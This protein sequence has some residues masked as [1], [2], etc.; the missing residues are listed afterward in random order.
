MKATSITWGGMDRLKLQVSLN[1]GWI[2]KGESLERLANIIYRDPQLEVYDKYLKNTQYLF[3]PEYKSDISDSQMDTRKNQPKQVIPYPSIAANLISSHIAPEAH[4]LHFSVDDADYQ[5]EIDDFIK[6]YAFWDV[7]KSALPSYFANGSMFIRFVAHKNGPINIEFEN[8]KWVFP[9]FN[10]WQELERVKIRRI[11]PTNEFEKGKRIWR[12]FQYSMGKNVDIMY[13]NPVFDENMSK[14]PDFKVVDSYKHGLG[15]VQGQWFKTSF[16]SH[17]GAD[18]NSFLE[19]SLDILD[20]YNYMTSKEGSSIY[21]HLFPLLVAYGVGSDKI[22]NLLKDLTYLDAHKIQGMNMMAIPNP[23]SESDLRFLEP[24][25]AGFAAAAE[26]QNRNQELLQHALSM[27]LLDPERVAAH[28]QS[29]VAMEAL[30]KPVVQFITDKRGFLERG[31][32]ELMN[33][34]S[35]VSQKMK[36]IYQLPESLIEDA[37][38]KWGSVFTPTDTDKQI[39][40]GYTVAALQ[41]GA[42]SKKTAVKHLAPD[43]GVVNVE[44]ELKQIEQEAQDE[45]DKQLMSMEGE[46]QIINK[47]QP[48]PAGNSNAKAKK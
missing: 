36:T 37:D 27:R 44:E 7:I 28:A 33:K 10:E 14:I 19:D 9:E 34:M 12:W 35:I 1:S 23:P 25:G 39:K 48:P 26:F 16:S 8:T 11:D 21:Y 47:N 30:F 13:D 6:M 45:M 38:K 22:K 15:F 17:S 43:F 42:I 40:V 29:G 20:N 31:I 4:N 46:Q 18:R 24:S 5:K 41:Q 2:Y 3:L 32:C